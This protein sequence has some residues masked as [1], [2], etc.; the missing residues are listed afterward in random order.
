MKKEKAKRFIRVQRLEISKYLVTH[1]LKA[2]H[3]AVQNASL[4]E[5]EELHARPVPS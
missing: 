1:G 5:R 2:Y 4:T 3:E